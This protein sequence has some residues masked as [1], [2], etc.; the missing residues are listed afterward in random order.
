MIGHTHAAG[1]RANL[2]HREDFTMQIDL[3]KLAP[4]K[5]CD[6]GKR[7]TGDFTHQELVTTFTKRGH[8]D[9]GHISVK[10]PSR[11]G[12]NLGL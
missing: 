8:S 5:G 12:H 7:K 3:R 2:G 11:Q 9:R 10:W 6:V 1:A 4:Q